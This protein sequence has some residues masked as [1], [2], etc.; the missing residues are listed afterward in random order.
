MAENFFLLI[1]S[2]ITVGIKGPNTVKP[3]A[4][5]FIHLFDYNQLNFR[6]CY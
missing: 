1:S 3:Y 2:Q 4:T 5:N 6:L